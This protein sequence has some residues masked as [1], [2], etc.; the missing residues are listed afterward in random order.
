MFNTHEE[1]DKHLNTNN[2]DA[3]TTEGINVCPHFSVCYARR[4]SL[5]D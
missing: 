4:E 3:Q 5:L 1:M 2:T